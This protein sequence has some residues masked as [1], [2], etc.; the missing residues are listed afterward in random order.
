MLAEGNLYEVFEIEGTYPEAVELMREGGL[1]Y[2]G[3]Q[4]RF[5]I[6][7]YRESEDEQWNLAISGPFPLKGTSNI[8]DGFLTGM[9]YAPY[10]EHNVDSLIDEWLHDYGASRI[11]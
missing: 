5:F 11:N 2:E 8:E 4:Y 6:Y 3:Q 7:R 10:E 9:L 1:L